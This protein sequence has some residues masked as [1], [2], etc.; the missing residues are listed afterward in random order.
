MASE[1]VCTFSILAL[2]LV[3][4]VTCYLSCGSSTP[5]SCSHTLAPQVAY[6][7]FLTLVHSGN[8][9]SAGIDNSADK[10]YFSVHGHSSQQAAEAAAEE[11]AAEAAPA[12]SR[13]AS[14]TSVDTNSGKLAGCVARH[15]DAVLHPFL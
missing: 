11:A 6:S 9:K 4:Q 2:H 3:L 7:H 1:P 10:I 13:S 15:T 8:V 12:A 5:A 14:A